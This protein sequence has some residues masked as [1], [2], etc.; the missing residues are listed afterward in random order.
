[1]P[2]HPAAHPRPRTLVHPGRA[3]PVRIHSMESPHARHLR[4]MLE[5]GRSLHAALVEPLARRGIAA[6]STTILGGG[7]AQLFYCVAPPDPQ[8]R[9]VIAYSDPIDAGAATM[10]FGNATIGRGLT[11]AVLVHCHAVLRT[12]AGAMAGG[13]ILPE[14]SIVGPAPIPV[15]V[16]VIEDFEIRQTHDPETNIALFQPRRRGDD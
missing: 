10:I 9:A 8:G 14:R 5:P 12:G 6:A 2:I 11:G 7:F 3:A 15:L 1:M 13:H 4:L 16:T